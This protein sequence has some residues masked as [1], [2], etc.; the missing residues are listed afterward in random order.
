MISK[1]LWLL[2]FCT[3]VLVIA[4]AVAS[5]PKTTATPEQSE[6][7]SPTK[8]KNRNDSL[9]ALT[10]HLGL[11]EGAAIADVG[12]GGGRDMQVFAEIVGKTGTVLAQEIVESK[13]KLI[14]K[15]AKENKLSQVRAIHGRDND[16]RLPAASADLAFT[17]YVYHH[18]AKPR[19]MLRGLWKSLKPGGYLVVVD[20]QRGT[21]SDWVARETRA[22]KHH[23][24]SE[25][26]VV[27]EAREEGFVYV[28]CAEDC[29]HGKDEFVLV[30]QRP[31]GSEKPGSD[32]DAFLPLDQ[33]EACRSV[34]PPGLA[35]QRPVIIALGEGRK[36]MAPI[37]ERASSGQAVEIVLEEWATQ[38][39]ERP[40]L[41]AGVSLPSVLTEKGDPKLGPE[42]IDAVFFLDSY[43][44]LFHQEALL[45]KLHERLSTGGCVYVLDRAAK[46]P[47]ARREASHR[48]KISPE[49]VKQ[50][51]AQAG[52]VFSREGLPPAA[53]R[54]LLVFNKAQPDET[55]PQN[56]PQVGE[57]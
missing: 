16:P 40:P 50:E 13:V 20:K 42:P 7:S 2:V 19:E 21:L 26:T 38:K 25:T 45:A 39:E 10:K 14:E 51:M 8:P 9:R 48:R 36:L 37:L 41:P 27:R 5:E 52:F 34:L 32:P 43:H 53:D 30:F 56:D 17:H 31:Q 15:K 44:L 46:E 55:A 23:W 47:L 54:L 24:T 29:W 11:G 22:K 35:C 18:F 33:E 57:K 3:S 12:A 1:K 49:T 28:E 4:P 6:K